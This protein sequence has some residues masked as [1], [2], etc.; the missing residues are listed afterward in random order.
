MGAGSALRDQVM[1]KLRITWSDE[2]TDARRSSASSA[3]RPS[4]SALHASN[5]FAKGGSFSIIAP[6]LAPTRRILP[7]QYTPAPEV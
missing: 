2:A 7:R 4:A 3:T 1:R 6:F 5:T